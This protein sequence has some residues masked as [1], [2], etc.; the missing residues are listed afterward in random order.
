M[1]TRVRVEGFRTLKDVTFY[2]GPISALVGRPGTGKSNLL[3]AIRAVLDPTCP[4][5]NSTDIARSTSDPILIAVETG[6]DGNA[7]LQG[8]PPETTLRSDG[9]LPPVVF[10]PASLRA[11][12]VVNTRMQASTETM[13]WSHGS[14]FQYSRTD[15]AVDQPKYYA[16][17][18]E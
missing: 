7:I 13:Q 16:R 10:W 4:P 8:R 11:Q 14:S 6:S 3:A 18:S 12:Q 5:L 1:L 9:L 2:P 17:G 15:P